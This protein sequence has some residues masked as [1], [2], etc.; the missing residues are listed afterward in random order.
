[1]DQKYPKHTYIE[2]INS[3]IK[4]EGNIRIMKSFSISATFFQVGRPSRLPDLRSWML[5]S[6]VRQLS[7]ETLTF[8]Y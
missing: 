7:L 5:P 3:E 2:S 4:A 6:V 8:K 1:M